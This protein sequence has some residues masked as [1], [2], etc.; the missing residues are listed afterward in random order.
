MHEPIDFQDARTFD[1]ALDRLAHAVGGL[2]FDA[3]DYGFMPRAR[4]YDGRYH[5]PTIVSRNFPQRW[6]RGWARYL[7]DDP[8]LYAAY[9]RN[10]PIDWE[11]VED[12][13]WLSAEQRQA[14]GYIRDHGFGSGVT[15]P[16]HLPDGAFAFVTAASRDGEATWRAATPDVSDRLLVLAHAFHAAQGPRPAAP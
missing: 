6:W 1:A 2:G 13:P 16:I 12:A 5:A 11:E 15:V 7:R 10:L 14:F 8:L 3:V 9:P 4:T